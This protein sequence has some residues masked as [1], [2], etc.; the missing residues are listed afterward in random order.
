MYSL[1][2]IKICIFEND[3]ELMH[4]CKVREKKKNVPSVPFQ[5]IDFFLTVALRK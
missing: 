3:T 4:N 1:H 5:T 2:T